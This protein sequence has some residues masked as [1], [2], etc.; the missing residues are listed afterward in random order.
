ME[1]AEHDVIIIGAGLA[2][3]AA[4]YRLSQAGKRI[5]I[6]EA[7]ARPG[8]R[9][10]ARRFQN[11]AASELL[12]YGGSWITPWH[13]RI[14][15]HCAT[16]G[17]SLRPRAAVQERLVMRDGLPAP[18]GFAD[19][20]ER[21]AHERALARIAAD[22]ALIKMG[23]AENEKG[24]ALTGLSYADYM[25][26]LQPPTVTRH[27]QDAW[28]V[29]SGGGPM[30][31]IS[32]GE[33]L[34]SCAYGGGLAEDIIEA[35]AD[36]VEPS[37]EALAAKLIAASRASVLIAAPVTSVMQDRTG[38][39]V[40]LD[41]GN[42]HDAAHAIVATGVNPLRAIGFTPPLQGLPPEAVARGQRGR[43]FKLWIRARGVSVGRHVTGS[44]SG[45]QMLFA[46]RTARDGSVLMI[47][48]GIQDERAA[49]ADPKWVRSE[50]ARLCP[51]AEFLG[52]DW[53][54][55]IADPFA[56]GTWLSTPFDMAGHFSSEAWEPQGR[57]AFASSDIAPEE[58]GW[59]EGAVRSG[60]AA[61]DWVTDRVD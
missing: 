13:H 55:W 15:A 6:I 36:T 3:A 58:A 41:S 49:P 48:F 53:H 25:A 7:Q 10:Y 20:G 43:A 17:L 22:A 5:L 32:A 44:S 40:T 26:R 33:F 31:E 19:D 56:R 60:E 2:G 9:A 28:W 4:A 54:D 34:S 38:V 47:G 23:L 11:D 35:W 16:F 1:S 42:T 14:R 61:A 37:M 46:E 59:F 30:D 39:R 12:E 21:R 27:M 18:L 50:F 24:E 29:A 52:Y 57:I 8:G 45:V 51:N